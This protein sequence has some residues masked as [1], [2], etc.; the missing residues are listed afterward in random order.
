PEA[1]QRKT[2][3]RPGRPR[4][5]RARVRVEAVAA[6][7]GFEGMKRIPFSAGFRGLQ[8]RA[9][10][11]DFTMA[12]HTRP[13]SPL[14]PGIEIGSYAMCIGST[15]TSS[16]ALEMAERFCKTTPTVIEACKRRLLGPTEADYAEMR[17]KSAV[18]SDDSSSF[19]AVTAAG[20]NVPALAVL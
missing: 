19:N 6:P 3:R 2:D 16:D 7:R 12:V 13:A 14:P 20:L 10:Q 11:E 8:Y 4:D 1:R 18:S 9:G 17:R 5:W 15:R